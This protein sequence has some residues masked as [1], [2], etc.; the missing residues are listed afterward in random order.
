MNFPAGIT[1]NGIHNTQS[2]ANDSGICPRQKS[3]W[4]DINWPKNSDVNEGCG[5]GLEQKEKVHR[6][7]SGPKALTLTP[8]FS[9]LVSRPSDLSSCAYSCKFTVLSRPLAAFV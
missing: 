1:N 4:V 9:K 3:F 5:V 6:E 8:P 2:I 7:V